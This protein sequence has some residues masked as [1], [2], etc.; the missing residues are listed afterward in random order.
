M[1]GVTAHCARQNELFDAS[2]RQCSLKA[3]Y[4]IRVCGT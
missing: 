3:S 1:T 2:G 4:R